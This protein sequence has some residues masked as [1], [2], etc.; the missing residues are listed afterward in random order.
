MFSSL[1]T[2][3]LNCKNKNTEEGN[4]SRIY[5]HVK[6]AQLGDNQRKSS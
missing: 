6:V 5:K 2:D 1:L 3:W 4:E